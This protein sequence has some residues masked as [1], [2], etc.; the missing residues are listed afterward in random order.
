MSHVAID[1]D[2]ARDATQALDHVAHEENHG[3][4]LTPARSHRVFH[5]PW[6]ST[7]PPWLRWH[8]ERKKLTDTTIYMAEPAWSAETKERLARLFQATKPRPDTP[9]HRDITV[10]A[11]YPS[12]STDW[13]TVC[14]TLEKDSLQA[15]AAGLFARVIKEDQG[16]LIAVSADGRENTPSE[17]DCLRCCSR[18]PQVLREWLGD[19]PFAAV[20]DLS[21]WKSEE[22]SEDIFTKC[23]TLQWHSDPV[24]DSYLI[25][26][27]SDS[28][29]GQFIPRDSLFRE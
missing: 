25:V 5:P 6:D 14:F 1:V 11:P 17:F 29:L 20:Q 3:I 8:M 19:I 26:D 27:I 24:M 2:Y 10:S 4:S 15:F 7:M 13:A 21:T 28:H 22:A 18:S 9:G 16:K 12:Q 23:V